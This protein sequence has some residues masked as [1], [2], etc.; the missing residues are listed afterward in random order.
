MDPTHAEHLLKAAAHP[1]RRRILA[2]LLDGPLCVEELAEQ[3]ALAASTVSH[4]L[5]LLTRAGVVTTRRVQYYVEYELVAGALDHTLRDLVAASEPDRL[6]AAVRARAARRE[7]VLAHLERGRLAR[8]PAAMRPREALLNALAAELPADRTLTGPEL[9][10][11]AARRCDRPAEVVDG[12]QTWELVVAVDG[13]WRAAP[14]RETITLPPLASEPDAG[15]DDPHAQARQLA[16][17]RPAGQAGVYWIK[18]LRTERALLGSSLDAPGALRWHRER[19]DRGEHP[20]ARLQADWSELGADA[21]ELELLETVAVPGRDPDAVDA[22][23]A[24]L[25]SA[26]IA[27]LQPFDEQCYNRTLDIRDAPY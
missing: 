4:H 21:F 2:L 6:E 8:L 22:A 19:L 24:R 12:W 11:A 25:E 18:N 23:L 14:P 10:A 15:A 7:L 13:G 1:S 20:S 27:G 17:R 9:L 16:Q 26:W 3:L 5:G